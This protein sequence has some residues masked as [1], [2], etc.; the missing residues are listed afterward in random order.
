MEA[1]DDR[2]RGERDEFKSDEGRYRFLLE[3]TWDILWTIDLS[4]NWKF[5]TG[6]VEKIVHIPLKDILGKTIWDFVAPEYVL[7]LKDKLKR[8]LKG[9]EIPPYDVV[10]I[11]GRGRGGFPSKW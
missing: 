10:V 11:N 2:S 1:I 7:M 4:G 5:M 8:R 6:D 3:N 9:E